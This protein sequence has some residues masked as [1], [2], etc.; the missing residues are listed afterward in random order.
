MSYAIEA[1]GLTKH[2]I[3]RKSPFDYLRRSSKQEIVAVQGVSFQIKA[4]ELFGLLGPNGAGK[5]TLIKL[6]STLI[7]PTSGM[8]RVNGYDLGNEDKVKAAIGLVTSA[9]RSFYWRLTGRENLQF[10]ASLFGLSPTQ[11]K[12][13]I[14]ELSALFDLEEFMDR[15]F[16]QCSSGIKQRLAL[17]RGMLHHPQ[18]LFLDEP[19]LNLDPIAAGRLRGTISDLVSRHGHTIFLITHNLQEA[20]QLCDRVAIMHRGRLQGVDRVNHLRKMIREE[21]CYQMEVSG[22]SPSALECLNHLDGLLNLSIEQ[23]ASDGSVKIELNLRDSHKHLPTI[24]KALLERG[25]QMESLQVKK[26]SLEEV[27]QRLT[28]SDGGNEI[29]PVK[30]S[31]V[32]AILDNPGSPSP[33]PP[34][35][36]SL[37]SKVLTALSFLQRDFR[38]QISYRFGFFLQI[39]G[40]LLSLPSFYFLSLLVDQRVVPQLQAYGGDYFAFVL[41]GIAFMGYQNVALNSFAR[42]IRSGQMMGT[43]E[44]MLMTPNRFSAILLSSSLWSLVLTSF[45]V[46]LYLLL[47]ITLFG[48][49]L[50][51]INLAGAFLTQLLTILAFSGIGILSASFIVVFKQETPINF[52]FASISG[53]LA[54]VLYPVEVLPR[55]LQSLSN[56]LPLTYSLRAM[57]KAVLLGDS[58]TGIS[59]DLLVLGLFACLLLPLG[60]SLFHYAVRCAKVH[61]S[62]TQF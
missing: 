23:P 42:T 56:L 41:V 28:E 13:R 12:T 31:A 6:L 50:D 8:A 36:F 62:L 19:T 25:G 21:N 39:V 33:D 53:L 38:L 45:E 30:E 15:R 51:R 14:K 10:F 16:D 35:P 1:Y 7:I 55:W 52:L 46:S 2:F 32:P 4:G 59:T 27:F 3:S 34:S 18:I 40:I 26:P 58:L 48:L 22:L 47:G 29:S 9:E 43:L 54:G 61:G 24:L 60:F 17:A 11:T 57:R 5:T 44:A 37:K 20:E 49:R